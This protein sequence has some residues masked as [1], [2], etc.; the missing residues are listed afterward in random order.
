MS[1][2]FL[3]LLL[4]PKSMDIEAGLAIRNG[5]TDSKDKPTD[6]ARGPGDCLGPLFGPGQSPGGGPG[7]KAPQPKIVFSILQ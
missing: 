1:M 3:N 2:L 6:H 5:V 4:L 7:G